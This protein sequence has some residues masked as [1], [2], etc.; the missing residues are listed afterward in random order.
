MFVKVIHNKVFFNHSCYSF[1]WG[2]LYTCNELHKKGRIICDYRHRLFHLFDKML[3]DA[4][5]AIQK[6]EMK[7]TY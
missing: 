3:N 2:D 4:I 1:H 6:S 5:N 7:T